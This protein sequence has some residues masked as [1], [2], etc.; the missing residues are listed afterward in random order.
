MRDPRT[1]SMTGAFDDMLADTRRALETLYGGERKAAP[2]RRRAEPD[3]RVPAGAEDAGQVLDA[4]YGDGWRWRVTDRHREAG[5]AV[6]TVAV[7]VGDGSGDESRTGR[8]PLGGGGVTG[9][10]GGIP[11]SLGG[12]A[13]DEDG[14]AARA[15]ADAF[16]Q[17]VAA[18]Q[19]R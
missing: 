19:A 10:A 9:T 14:A 5:D 13:E 12:A 2:A 15:T 1:I 3:S 18:L 6:V 11:F 8:A 4:R 16:R 17:C 7:T